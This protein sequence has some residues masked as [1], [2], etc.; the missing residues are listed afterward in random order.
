MWRI[1]VAAVLAVKTRLSLLPLL[2]TVALQASL[3]PDKCC[4]AHFW[5]LILFGTMHIHA[6]GGDKSTMQYIQNITMTDPPLAHSTVH[7]ARI[8]QQL[9]SFNN[10]ADLLINSLLLEFVPFYFYELY[11]LWRLRHKGSKQHGERFKQFIKYCIIR[12]SQ[13]CIV[14]LFLFN[15]V[16]VTALQIEA[17]KTNPL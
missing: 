4:T 6:T 16:N 2:P 1:E 17:N 3:L 11:V 5:H 13:Q 7:T 15:I 10:P 9:C 14:S 12:K 8:T